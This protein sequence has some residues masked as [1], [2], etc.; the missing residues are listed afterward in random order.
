MSRVGTITTIL[1]K[2]DAELA[3]LLAREPEYHGKVVLSLNFNA[4]RFMN[5]SCGTHKM[6]PGEKVK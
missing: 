3:D 4:G 2:V 5:M 1:C 6:I